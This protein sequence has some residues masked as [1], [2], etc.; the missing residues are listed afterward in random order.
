MTNRPFEILSPRIRLL[1]KTIRKVGIAAL[2]EFW[3]EMERRETPLIE[4]DSDGYDNNQ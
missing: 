3:A 1:H 4:S 2:S